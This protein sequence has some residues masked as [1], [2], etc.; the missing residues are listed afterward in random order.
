MSLTHIFTIIGMIY[1]SFLHFFLHLCHKVMQ[2]IY[3]F[4]FLDLLRAA[5]LESFISVLS[6]R[7]KKITSF[8][9]LIR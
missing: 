1:H 9:F 2:C 8:I 4:Y 6:D 5:I 7:L 3:T